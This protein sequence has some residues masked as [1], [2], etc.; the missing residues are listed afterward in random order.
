[1]ASTDFT[2]T[3]RGPLLSEGRMD[4]ADFSPAIL[5]VDE[6]F[7]TA[8]LTLH[9]D[10]EPV[11]VQIEA[12]KQGSLAVQLIVEASSVWGQFVDFMH[13]D[14]HDA[15]VALF[16]D[17]FSVYGVV[18]LFRKLRGRKVEKE[19]HGE[20]ENLVTVTL[21]DGEKITTTGGSLRLIKIT[22]VQQ[23]VAR[24][25][26][27]LAR[28]GIEELEISTATSSQIRVEKSDLDSFEALP[29][30]AGEVTSEFPTEL[31]V[32]SATFR[33]NKKWRFT[34][35][36]IEFSASISDLTFLAR[37]DAG[38]KFAKG[39]HLSVVLRQTQ[40]R[41]TGKLR[42]EREVIEVKHHTQPS[43]ADRLTQ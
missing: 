32:V 7:K 36:D 40:T 19:E 2:L 16:Q 12:T 3:Y 22:K 39:D 10:K 8:S 38:E 34:D 21:E 31:E 28:D 20:P 35:G 4:V 11:K 5:A 25:V 41:S 23:S 24:I 30:E 43:D 29:D 33:E 17:V 15:L 26:R 6:L 14:D 18:E 42:T 27:P 1:M 37:V 9:P 13:S